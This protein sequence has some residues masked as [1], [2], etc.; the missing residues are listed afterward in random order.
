MKVSILN[1]AKE[2]NTKGLRKGADIKNNPKGKQKEDSQTEKLWQLCVE[3]G[4]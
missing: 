4:S 2:M 1:L 3:E